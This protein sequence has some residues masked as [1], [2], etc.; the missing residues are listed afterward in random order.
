MTLST[1]GAITWS[2]ILLTLLAT[3]AVSSTIA[4]EVIEYPKKGPKHAR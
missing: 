1:V 2:P 4:A 3:T